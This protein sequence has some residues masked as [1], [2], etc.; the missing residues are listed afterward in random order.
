ML[1][2]KPFK[3]PS[4]DS[5][6]SESQENN[7]SKQQLQTSNCLEKD[8]I[9]KA[10]CD[11]LSVPSNNR[12]FIRHQ[13]SATE[14]EHSSDDEESLILRKKLN[15]KTKKDLHPL[16]KKSTDS[17][18][19]KP[20]RG[21]IPSKS[22]N[23]DPF[24]SDMTGTNNNSTTTPSNPTPS[25]PQKSIHNRFAGAHA[26]FRIAHASFRIFVYVCYR[27]NMVL[28]KLENL[29]SIPSLRFSR[30]D[31]EIII[32]PEDTNSTT[33]LPPVSHH[34]FGHNKSTDHFT[35]QFAPL[36]KQ[37]SLKS[38]KESEGGFFSPKRTFKMA[39]ASFRN[40]IHRE[41]YGLETV[42]FIFKILN[43]K[44]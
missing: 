15:S 40:R 2:K 34:E 17:I 19:E 31:S 44:I 43:K 24:T 6:N 21:S 11:S 35:Q 36:P 13:L 39:H 4:T 18:S 41:M 16:P 32:M 20:P 33:D 3:S 26:S 38:K 30:S 7:Q 1:S 12:Q 42:C 14:E 27:N 25:S 22:H 9:Q 5:S 8:S 10:P 28:K 29:I 37:G 23:F